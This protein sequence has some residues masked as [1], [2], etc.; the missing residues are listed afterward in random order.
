MVTIEAV[1]LT[2]GQEVTII[3]EQGKQ[4]IGFKIFNHKVDKEGFISVEKNSQ[5]TRIHPKR[6]ITGGQMSTATAEMETAT[7]TTTP[8]TTKQ[9]K[10]VAKIITPKPK[11]VPEKVDLNSLAANGE[12][13]IKSGVEFDNKSDVRA[14][15]LIIES[16]ERYLSFNIYNGTYGKKGTPPPIDEVL[17]GNEKIGYK[18]SP[19]IEK[20]RERFIRNGYTKHIV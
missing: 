10:V 1:K 14:C 20:L 8:A 5:I 15:A 6:I 7:A 9:P 17:K 18:I 3:N 4:E 12:L 19:N 13:W 11:A 2:D 16:K